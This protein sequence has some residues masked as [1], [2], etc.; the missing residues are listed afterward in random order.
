MDCGCGKRFAT[1]GTE[2]TE[3]EDAESTL[4]FWCPSQAQ[5]VGTYNANGNVAQPH[6]ALMM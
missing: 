6:A 4:T 3:G 2:N 5:L 1:E